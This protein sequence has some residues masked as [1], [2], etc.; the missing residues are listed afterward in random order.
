MSSQ[1]LLLKEKFLIGF[2][3][4]CAFSVTMFCRIHYTLILFDNSTQAA[5]F[6]AQWTT[7]LETQQLFSRTANS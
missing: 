5:Q 2:S 3:N 7:Y 4:I 6:W 1:D